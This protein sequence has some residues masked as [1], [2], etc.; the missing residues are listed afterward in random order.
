MDVYF[1]IDAECSEERQTPFRVRP[2]LGVDLAVRGRLAN[3]SPGLGT[4]LLLAELNRV[5]VP[6]TFFVESLC[7][8]FFG[9]EALTALIGDM[10]RVGHDIQLHLHPNFKQPEWRVIGAEPPED[11]IGAYPRDDQ[12]RLLEDGIRHLV[13][14]GVP[15]DR[16]CAFRAGNF[17]AT[18][19][20]WD[21]LTEVGLH[22]SSSL[23][24][25]NFDLNCLITPDR[26]RVDLY[27]AIPGVW[28]LPVS[29]F[30]EGAVYRPL[31]ITA[32]SFAEMR[33][34]LESL[35]ATGHGCATILTHP[36]EFF[37][38]DDERI[39]FGRPNHINI[40]RLRRLLDYLNRE[41]GRY[42]LRTVGWLG[43]Q[44]KSGSITAPA[45]VPPIPFGSARQRVLR[46]A[47]QF[48]KRVLMRPRRP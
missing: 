25:A 4:D 37:T 10:Q 12:V 24:L 23:N 27:E 45:E 1:T 31:Q 19:S 48:M 41:R 14:C 3:H 35:E 13:R 20:T 5:E 39:P 16:L 30:R 15:R 42:N 17:G 7:T 28:E 32:I 40:R 36:E 22:V 33:E 43:K 21:A 18:N 34:A 9:D 38:I 46:H 47:S 6:A 8:E 2:P 26:P 11:N 44:L 29:C